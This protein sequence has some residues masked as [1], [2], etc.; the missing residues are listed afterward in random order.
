MIRKW[1]VTGAGLLWIA[2]GLGT[3]AGNLWAVPQA[4]AAQAQ[5]KPAYTLAEYNA[6]KDADGEQ[7]PQQRISKL[8]AFVKQ[9][10]NSTLMPYVY[11]DYYTTDMAM[12]NYA[13]AIDYCRSYDRP[14]RQD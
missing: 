2:L 3:G 10:P 5:A 1:M 9:Y 4:P 6:Y 12:K 11:R 14:R 7:N 8:D 13:Q